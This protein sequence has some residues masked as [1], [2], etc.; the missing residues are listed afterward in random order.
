MGTDVKERWMVPTSLHIIFACLI[1]ILSWFQYESP[2]FLIKRGKTAEARHVMSRLRR[3][4]E[5]D[6]YVANEIA[7]IQHAHD[8]EV[9]ATRGLTLGQ[10]IKETFTTKGNLYRLYLTTSVQFLSQWSGAGS[11]TI[12]A[13]D[14]FELLGVKGAEQGLLVT[15]VF[16][17]VKLTAALLCA[18][19]LVDV[20][21]RKRSLLLGISLQTIAMVYV[22]SF[23]SSHPRLGMEDDYHLPTKDLPVSRGAIAMIYLSGFGWALGWNSMQ[24]LLTAELFPLRIRAI[25]TS[26]AMALHFGNQFGNARAVPNL[27]LPTNKGGITAQGTFWSFACVTIIGGLWVWFFVPETAGRSLEDMSRLFELP[28]YKVGRYGNKFA[29]EQEAEERRE[30]IDEDKLEDVQQEYDDE[31]ARGRKNAPLV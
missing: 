3:L 22:A 11:I 9:E 1:F 27:L 15:A 10:T 21:G 12:Y 20:I 17:L 7:S 23:L 18:L 4:P 19:F 30:D 31:A 6:P 28:W 5:T 29:E 8:V 13:P 24:Y 26:W 16:G 14:F 25:G 2:R